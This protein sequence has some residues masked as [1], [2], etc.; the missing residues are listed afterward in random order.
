MRSILIDM[1]FF[2]GLWKMYND[3]IVFLFVFHAML[4]HN[5]INVKFFDLIFLIADC[6]MLHGI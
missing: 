1:L 3:S 2:W 4:E 6:L 5:A